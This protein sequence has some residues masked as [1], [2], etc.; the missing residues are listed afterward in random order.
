MKLLFAVLLSLGLTFVSAQLTCNSFVSVAEGFSGN[1]S[2]LGIPIDV[3]DTK[4]KECKFNKTQEQWCYYAQIGQS[5]KV[6]GCDGVQGG[7]PFLAGATAAMCKGTELNLMKDSK[8]PVCMKNTIYGADVTIC[9]CNKKN[10][11]TNGKAPEANFVK[12]KSFFKKDPVADIAR[13]IHLS[14]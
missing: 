11:F 2:T 10:C 8:K 3:K 7:I 14:F 12:S 4:S 1:M 5:L 13:A 6:S 9:C